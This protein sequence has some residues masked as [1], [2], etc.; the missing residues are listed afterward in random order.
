MLKE[1]F[2]PYQGNR[3]THKRKPLH[4]TL[5]ANEELL[6]GEQ[7]VHEAL[8]HNLWKHIQP[9]ETFQTHLSLVEEL[10]TIVLM[11]I[12]NALWKVIMALKCL[13]A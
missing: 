6:Y 1:M 9:V 11:V 3:W 7:I 5:V 12:Q 8:R 10:I 13:H 4:R 2:S